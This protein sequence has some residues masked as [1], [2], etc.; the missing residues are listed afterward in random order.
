MKVEVQCYSLIFVTLVTDNHDITDDRWTLKVDILITKKITDIL[1]CNNNPILDYTYFYSVY[2]L[3]KPVNS[4]NQI[5]AL[6]LLYNKCLYDKKKYIGTRTPVWGVGVFLHWHLLSL[7]EKMFCKMH[8]WD[9]LS[10]D[11]GWSLEVG[12]KVS[13]RSVKKG[14]GEYLRGISAV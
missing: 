3:W 4:E 12:G 14:I 5:S 13:C 2:P 6:S 7:L 11:R 9:S 1:L 10:G 8:W